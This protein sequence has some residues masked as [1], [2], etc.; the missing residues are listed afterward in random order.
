MQINHAMKIIAWTH[1]RGY[2]KR[3]NEKNILTNTIIIIIII[4]IIM[5]KRVKIIKTLKRRNEKEL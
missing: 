2:L 5:K 3:G 4:I 1:P